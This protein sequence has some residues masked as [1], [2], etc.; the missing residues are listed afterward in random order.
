MWTNKNIS[1][2]PNRHDRV[3]FRDDRSRSEADKNSNRCEN[4][5]STGNDGP[6][7]VSSSVDFYPY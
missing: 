4:E 1:A 2:Q 3:A 6:V 7:Y 5:A